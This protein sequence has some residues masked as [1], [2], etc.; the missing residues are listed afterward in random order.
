MTTLTN[1]FTLDPATI[2]TILDEHGIPHK[3]SNDGKVLALDI[4]FANDE[5]I[6]VWIFAPTLSSKLFEWLG[7]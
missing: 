2:K 6:Q 7:Y 5:P 1:T 4:S 3:M